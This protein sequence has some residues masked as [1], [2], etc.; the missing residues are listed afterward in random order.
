[1]SNDVIFKTG[2]ALGPYKILRCIGRGG[3][4]EVYEVVHEGLGVHYALKA[5]T[6]QGR[7]S[8]EMLRAKFMEEG[9]VLARLKHPNLVRVFDLMV[10]GATGTAYYVMDFVRY[11][12]GNAYTL[13]DVDSTSVDEDQLYIWFRDVCNALDY[14][15]SKG[16]VHRDVKLDN[17]LLNIDKHAMLSDFGVAHI[18]GDG[19]V[20]SAAGADATSAFERTGEL[21]IL[22]TNHYRAPEVASGGE[23][24]PAADT[25]ALGVAMFRML[26]GVWYEPGRDARALLSGCAYKYRWA[27]VLP[28]LLATDPQERMQILA[29]AVIALLPN[30]GH[31]RVEANRLL[32]IDYNKK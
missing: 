6:Y 25:Y 24:T 11:K 13:A 5:F 10:D 20:K 17:I 31:V 19:M 2:Q 14:I 3:M 23:A 7:K 30:D 21:A 8:V 16:V 1:M 26:T 28:Q 32:K 22:G 4:G 18:F 27:D 15:H 9:Q 29:Q 12:D